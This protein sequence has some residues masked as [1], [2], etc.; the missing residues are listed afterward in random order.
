MQI[1]F[2]LKHKQ[3]GK[4]KFRKVGVEYK[5]AIVTG[6]LRTEGCHNSTPQKKYA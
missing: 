5:I 6:Y 3:H 2:K 4:M 1:K